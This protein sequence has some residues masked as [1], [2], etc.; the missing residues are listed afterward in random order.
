VSASPQRRVASCCLVVVIVLFFQRGHALRPGTARVVSRVGHSP[1]CARAHT[2]THTGHDASWGFG[3]PFLTSPCSGVVARQNNLELGINLVSL[4]P[5]LNET[6]DFVDG[7]Y[8]TQPC[9]FCLVVLECRDVWVSG[10]IHI[11]V[12]SAITLLAGLLKE[13]TSLFPD[14]FLHLGGDEVSPLC[15]DSVPSIAEF[16][17][18]RNMSSPQLQAW[19]TRQILPIVSKYNKRAVFWQ[20][21]FESGAVEVGASVHVVPCSLIP[22]SE[23]LC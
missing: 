8:R 15:W 10:C 19:F 16:M 17:A 13:V 9:C 2:H 23:P 12:S 7:S 21:A 5:T 11:A 20:E 14:P 22:R 3:Y 18:A 1:L 6:L 4:N